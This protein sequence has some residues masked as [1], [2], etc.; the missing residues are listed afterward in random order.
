SAPSM[1]LRL[2]SLGIQASDLLAWYRSFHPDVV[3]GVTAEQYFTGGMILRGWP[4]SL[5]SAALSSSGGIVNVPGFAQ[6]VRIGL[7]N[8]GCER[9]VLAIGPVRVA[10][11]GELRD[12]MTPKRRRVALAME[13]AADLTFT[14]D[15]NTQAGSI[16]IEGNF[17]KA[18]NFLKLSAAFG[19][20]LKK[21]PSILMLPACVFRSCV[22]V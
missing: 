4:L 5:E 21:F 18:E 14:H 1:E 7:F 2:D 19:R 15:L 20:Q 9:G 22:K 6:P 13:N 10:L 3:E 8:G 16:S 11:G 12:V 17:F